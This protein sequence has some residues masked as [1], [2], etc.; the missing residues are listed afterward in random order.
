MVGDSPKSVDNCVKALSLGVISKA[1]ISVWNRKFSKIIYHKLS[2]AQHDTNFKVFFSFVSF[3]SFCSEKCQVFNQLIVWCV[4]LLSTIW[5]LPRV[6]IL[7][8]QILYQI[9]KMNLLFIK[10][11]QNLVFFLFKLTKR[12]IV[13]TFGF[14]FSSFFWTLNSSFNEVF[15]QLVLRCVYCKL[16]GC[17]WTQSSNEW[18]E[19]YKGAQSQLLPNLQDEPHLQTEVF[20]FCAESTPWLKLWD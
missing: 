5:N 20:Y 1:I 13:F 2:I 14:F 15:H 17:K 8:Y 10:K 6:L 18:F 9:W 7:K 19:I 12:S 4:N 3:V 11:F 16:K